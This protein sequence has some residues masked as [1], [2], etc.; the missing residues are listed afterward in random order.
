MDARRFGRD[1]VVKRIQP[2]VRVWVY[3]EGGGNDCN[4]LKAD[5]REAFSRFF[6]NAGLK[7]NRPRLI[8]CGSRENAFHDF[9]TAI[10]QGKN[11]L[12][13]V[14]SEAP[15]D[16]AHEPPPIDHF[17]PWA[18]LKLRDKWDKPSQASDPDCHLMVHCMENWFFADWEAV[19]KFFGQG[20]RSDAKPNQACEKVNKTEALNALE[21]ATRD[22]KKGKYRKGQHS[23]KLLALISSSQL[24]AAS[25][26]AKRFIDEIVKRK[27]TN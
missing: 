21:K 5:M 26:W 1:A 13:L 7:D 17:R 16:S 15:V 25:P 10:A 9:C 22:C 6:E 8:P 20:F 4:Q 12:L 19:A 27:S 23:F 11:A 18:H 24:L 2:E 14:D 3:A